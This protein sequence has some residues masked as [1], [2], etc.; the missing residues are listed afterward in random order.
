M[1]FDLQRYST[2]D[3]PGIRTL[4]FLKGCSL[5]CLWCQNPESRSPKPDILLDRRQC[6]EG[7]QLC[8]QACPAILRDSEGIQLSRSALKADDMERLRGLCPSEA[9]Q[10][11]GRDETLDTLM[12]TILRDRPFFERSGGG[13]TLSGGEPFMQPD[14]TA[15]LLA[16]CKAEGLHTAVESCLHVPWHQIEPSLPS[17]DLVL[18][19]LKH[20]DKERFFHWTRGKVELPIANLKCLAEHGVPMQIRVPLIPG[21]NADRASIEAITDTAASLGTVQEIHFLPY[22]TLGMGKYALLDLP[23]Q[24][25][26]TPLDDPD[27]LHFAHAYAQRQGLTPVTRG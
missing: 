21:F 25:P 13:I 9:L 12:D 10:V 23:Y 5:A 6:I 8:S 20:V 24:A 16:R 26:E 11:C 19:D 2:H 17:L 18:A 1:I 7:C 3:G 14:F 22:H 4:V 15:S 27:L